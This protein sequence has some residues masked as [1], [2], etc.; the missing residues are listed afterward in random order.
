MSQMVL[1]QLG[2]ALAALVGAS[3]AFMFGVDR[4]ERLV[5]SGAAGVLRFL[6]W[7]SGLL[8]GY[9]FAALWFIVPVIRGER[10]PTTRVH[11]LSGAAQKAGVVSGDR[12]VSIDSRAMKSWPELQDA[13]GS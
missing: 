5:G 9:V 3:G 13:I 4:G 11:V 7:A 2:A 10:E 1:F 8:A 6:P 12:I